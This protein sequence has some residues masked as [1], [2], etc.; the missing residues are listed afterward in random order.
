MI[1]EQPWLHRWR[2]YVGLDPNTPALQTPQPMPIGRTLIQRSRISD[3]GSSGRLFSLMGNGEQILTKLRTSRDQILHPPQYPRNAI[4]KF[5]CT[6]LRTGRDQILHP[7]QYLE[8]HAMQCP[9]LHAR[10]AFNGSSQTVLANQQTA[11]QNNA[12]SN[13]S[14]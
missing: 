12:M 11:R 9:T 5:A 3:S 1:H 13:A 14:N 10:P 6:K 4:S 8:Q 2:L 7:P